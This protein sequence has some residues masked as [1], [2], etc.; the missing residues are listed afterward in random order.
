MATQTVAQLFQQLG[1]SLWWTHITNPW[2]PPSEMGTDFDSGGF[3]APVG[4]IAGGRVVC[5]GQPYAGDPA[6]SS[7]NWVVQIETPNGEL[8]HYQHLWSPS[9]TV[10]ETVVAGQQ[11][12]TQGGCPTM[13]TGWSAPGNGC[14]C[15][16]RDDWTTGSHIEVRYSPSYNASGGV[17]NQGWINPMAAFLRAAQQSTSGNPPP[18]N[19]GPGPGPVPGPLPNPFSANENV[20]QFLVALDQSATLY[21]PFLVTTATQDTLSFPGGGLSFTDPI[22][23]IQGF[24]ENLVLDTTAIIFRLLLMFFGVVL[25]YKVFTNFVDVSKVASDSIDKILPL[26]TGGGGGISL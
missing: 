10:G 23:W 20:R 26:I 22:S 3:G 4:C 18:P 19:P 5:V 15:Q 13:Q 16:C 6:H 21:N 24:G 17:W 14:P 7:L 2:N 9:M 1:L 8:Y 25:I 11:V 12:G